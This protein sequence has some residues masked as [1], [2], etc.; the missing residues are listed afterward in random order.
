MDDEVFMPITDFQPRNLQD[1]MKIFEW[2][3]DRLAS[4]LSISPASVNNYLGNA[5]MTNAKPSNINKPQFITLLMYMQ[6]KIEEQDSLALAFAAFAILCPGISPYRPDKLCLLVQNEANDVDK[7][8]ICDTYASTKW[9]P[10][11][12]RN[13]NIF[14]DWQYNG[15]SKTLCEYKNIETVTELWNDKTPVSEEEK[16]LAIKNAKKIIPLYLKMF[17]SRTPI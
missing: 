10:F 3:N 5:S 7:K 9:F 13:I 16:E 14:V 15:K 8:M 1:I 4:I 12:I 17:I 6:R 2:D 11:A